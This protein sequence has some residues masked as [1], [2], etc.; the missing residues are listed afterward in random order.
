MVALRRL[1]V[2]D[3]AL[4]RLRAPFFLQ[5][6]NI[7][8]E[9]SIEQLKGHTRL[10]GDPGG[11]TCVGVASWISMAAR[12]EPGEGPNGW[13]LGTPGPKVTKQN[14]SPKPW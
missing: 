14:Y 11:N 12:M 6:R 4:R 1:H 5:C 9:S 3:H 8:T 10:Q 2:Y 7:T 13:T